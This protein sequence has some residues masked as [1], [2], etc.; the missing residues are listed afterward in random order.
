LIATLHH[1]SF[2]IVK[3]QQ[4][5]EFEHIIHIIRGNYSKIQ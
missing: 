1:P 2:G 4:Q 5:F 3:E